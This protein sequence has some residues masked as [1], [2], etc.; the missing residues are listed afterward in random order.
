[1]SE[2]V[3]NFSKGE[4]ASPAPVDITLGDTVIT[5]DRMELFETGQ[6]A[7][8]TGRVRMTLHPSSAAQSEA[9]Q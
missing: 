3:V 4:I 1:M 7:I 5:A 8:F 9:K 6:R 2:A